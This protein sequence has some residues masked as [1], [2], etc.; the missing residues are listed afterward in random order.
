VNLLYVIAAYG[1]EY[2]AGEI[3]RELGREIVRQGDHFSVLSFDSAREEQARARAIGPWD[4]DPVPVFRSVTAGRP[5]LDVVNMLVRP[6][7][8]YERFLPAYW[9]VARHLRTHP[10]VDLVLA[11]GAYPFGAVVA[12][13]C[14]KRRRP[15]VV[16]VAGGDFIAS[17]EAGYGYGRFRFARRLMRF[18][19]RNA[20][21]VRVTTPLVRESA[22][23]LGADPRKT[24]VI[25]RNV[26]EEVF[27]AVSRLGGRAQARS[28]VE[29]RW[30][31]LPGPLLVGAGRLHPIKGFGD[32][33]RALAGLRH[34]FPTARLF[35]AGPDRAGHQRE[36][37]GL[38]AEQG[39]A[40]AVDFPGALSTADLHLLLA[41]ADLVVVPSIVEGMNKV[42]VEAAALGS[43]C[44]VTRTTGIAEA[45]AEAGAGVLVE[46]QEPHG[47]SAGIA[48][49]LRDPARRS[50]MGEAGVAFAEQFRPDLIAHKMRG[51][52]ERAIEMHRRG[53]AGPRGTGQKADA[54]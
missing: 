10:E 28:S 45:L 47:L 25:P 37:E 2:M 17:H 41:A 35:L 22:V 39:V 53:G 23:E 40:G 51:L 13:A 36:L 44:V 30:G 14:A 43:P 5:F 52:S 16:T 11:E 31:P 50:A 34:D 38:A 26:A 3:H 27:E 1:P 48:A 20:A 6:V 46:P 21:A 4:G 7:A 24:V 19:L 32:A 49:L 29:R 54:P 18:A 42:A 8:R 12:Q 9:A 15:Y 33:I